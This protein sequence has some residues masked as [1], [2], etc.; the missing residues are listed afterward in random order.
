M[1]KEGEMPK[2]IVLT[3][4]IIGAIGVIYSLTLA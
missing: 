4:A 1:E 2:N 3:L